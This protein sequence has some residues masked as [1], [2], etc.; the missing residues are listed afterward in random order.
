PYSFVVSGM[1]RYHSPTPY[2]VFA[3]TDVNGDGFFSDLGPR[4]DH[5]N[6]HRGNSF[7]QLDLR[8]SKM[9]HFGHDMGIEL[10]VEV[11]NVFNSTNPAGYTTFG[12]PTNYAGDPLRGEQRLGQVGIRALF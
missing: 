2:T 11:F 9:F 8:A 1:F 12:E 5:V 4:E 10:I 6:A 3:T 7:T